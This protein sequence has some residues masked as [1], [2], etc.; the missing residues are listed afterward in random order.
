M[1]EYNDQNLNQSAGTPGGETVNA[2][3]EANAAKKPSRVWSVLSFILAILSIICCC[4]SWIPLILGA[5]AIVFA[6]I[7]R[8]KLGYFDGLGIAGLIIA[9]FGV[10][11]S[12]A[13]I[14]IGIL[15][16]EQYAEFLSEYM[17]AFEDM[18]N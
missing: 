17:G 10:V 3:P 12:L 4:N 2:A 16:A 5:V 13:G 8:S 6:I 1:N 11:F 9:I 15:F 7:S 14:L 18:L